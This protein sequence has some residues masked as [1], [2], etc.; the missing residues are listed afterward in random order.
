M[1]ENKKG[2]NFKGLLKEI[3]YFTTLQEDLG[4]ECFF[5]TCNHFQSYNI[6][7]NWL[8]KQVDSFRVSQPL[9][10]RC[11]PAFGN[12]GLKDVSTKLSVARFFSSTIFSIFFKSHS[13]EKIV[14]HKKEKC[15]FFILSFFVSFHY[16]NV[17]PVIF[18]WLTP[19]R[20]G[21]S[22]HTHKHTTHTHTYTQAQLKRTH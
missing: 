18:A 7:Y 2:Y 1:F 15:L 10:C 11:N 9:Q 21:T 8:Q 3:V 17:F 5:L 19:S 12:I 13:S 6:L 22:P 20:N 4:S 14:C 16:S